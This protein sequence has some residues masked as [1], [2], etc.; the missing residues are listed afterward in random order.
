MACWS[1]DPHRPRV[2]RLICLAYPLISVSPSTLLSTVDLSKPP[3]GIEVPILGYSCIF[4]ASQCSCASHRLTSGGAF[5]GDHGEAGADM[6]T[7]TTWPIRSFTC[8]N[9]SS[10]LS[11]YRCG[12]LTNQNVSTDCNH[13]T[14]GACLA[15]PPSNGQHLRQRA[16]HPGSR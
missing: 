6:R 16:E 15:G 1:G 3:S 4:R 8:L 12:V 11:S 2:N 9:P 5:P 7:G 14:L 10:I 13:V